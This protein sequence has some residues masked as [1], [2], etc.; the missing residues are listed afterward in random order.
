VAGRAALALTLRAA[1]ARLCRP[2]AGRFSGAGETP[3]PGIGC[4]AAITLRL[5]GRGEEGAIERLGELSGRPRPPGAYLLAEVD[6][7]P[8]AAVPLAGGEPLADPFR[9]TIE[10]KALLN[11][12]AAQLDATWRAGRSAEV[13]RL[14]G[15][16]GELLAVER[17][18]G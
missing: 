15:P 6:G 12:R 18:A 5:A 1:V 17:Q 7:Q 9:P 11:L 14:P 2:F 3:P 8:W 13:V 10:L 4:T 16:N